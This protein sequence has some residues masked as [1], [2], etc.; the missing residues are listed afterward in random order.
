M[1]R[2]PHVTAEGAGGSSAVDIPW[3]PGMD[4]CQESLL[5][6]GGWNEVIKVSPTKFRIHIAFCLAAHFC[7]TKG[8]TWFHLTFTRASILAYLPPPHSE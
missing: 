1:S 3:L 2:Y 6:R 4:L 8:N 5:R 7:E